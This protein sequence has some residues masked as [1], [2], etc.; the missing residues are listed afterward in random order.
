MATGAAPGS[1]PVS[2][3]SDGRRCA[4]KC[5]SA[6]DGVAARAGA[7]DG[8][9]AITFAH[10]DAAALLMIPRTWKHSAADAISLRRRVN[11]PS[12]TP[13][14]SAGGHF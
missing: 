4:G 14:A 11:L 2:T 9:S 3:G 8:S 10:F 12:R 1:T 7:P 13:N 5:S 6:T